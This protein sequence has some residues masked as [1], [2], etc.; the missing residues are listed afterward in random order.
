MRRLLSSSCRADDDDDDD[1]ISSLNNRLV[2]NRL[3][4]GLLEVAVD[5]GAPNLSNRLS[6]LTESPPPD[7]VTN[8]NLN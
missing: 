4:S 2:R 5:G 8:H 7:S 3:R 6:E 1:Y